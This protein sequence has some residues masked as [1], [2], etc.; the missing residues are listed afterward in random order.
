MNNM[1]QKGSVVR[2]QTLPIEGVYL[3]TPHDASHW[4]DTANYERQRPIRQWH[5][6]SLVREIIAGRFREKTQVSFCRLGNKYMLINGQHTLT[7]IKNSGVACILSVVIHN[8][9]DMDRVADLYAQEDTHLTRRFADSLVAH[10][11]HTRLGITITEMS[12]V[13]AACA[14]FAFMIGELGVKGATASTHTEK[15]ILTRKYG[16]LAVSVLRIIVN[17]TGSKSSGYA[18]RKTTIA[19]MM[20]V[21]RTDPDLCEQFWGEMFKDD[22]LRI[23]DPRKTLLDLFREST[24]VG[25]RFGSATVKKTLAD[26]HL[27][28]AQAAAFNAF[29]DRRQLKLI[30]YNN[31]EKTAEFKGI[32]VVRV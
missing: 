28:K 30:R 9:N 5:V 24:T 6:A 12:W 18:N 4:L 13:A 31:N 15:L 1:N 2:L 17:P 21:F 22:G 14:Y 20:F 25:G 19:P 10:D 11:E 26:H 23:G 16:D 29:V 3:V 27:V 7:A 8:V 32:G